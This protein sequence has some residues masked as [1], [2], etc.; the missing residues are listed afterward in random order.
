MD[1]DD[2]AEVTGIRDELVT[3]WE[4]SLSRA[5]YEKHLEALKGTGIEPPGPN[6]MHV[7]HGNSGVSDE[8]DSE[9]QEERSENNGAD[10]EAN[11]S[12]EKQSVDNEDQ[13]EGENNGVDNEANMSPGTE[14]ELEAQAPTHV[15]NEGGNS[16]VGDKSNTNSGPEANVE[17]E[18]LLLKP[19]D[20]PKPRGRRNR[21]GKKKAKRPVVE[22]EEDSEDQVVRAIVDP[23]RLIDKS[24]VDEGD[25]DADGETDFVR[26]LHYYFIFYC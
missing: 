21:R 2:Q 4:G 16:E 15:D 18:D 11:V 25:A 10:D 7:D 17:D 9:D 1:I 3:A 13:E 22:S 20:V 5:A 23:F 24:E 12:P 26:V 14:A 19:K 8:E 6:P